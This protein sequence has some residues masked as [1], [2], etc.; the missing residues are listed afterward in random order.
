MGVV[1]IEKMRENSKG[2]YSEVPRLVAATPAEP[3]DH[4]G[5]SPETGAPRRRLDDL[6]NLRL[7]GA[8]LANEEDP[9]DYV[10]RLREG[11]E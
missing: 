10:R 9:D 2:E 7:A 8:H 3:T 11:W 4:A 6:L 1:E 5:L